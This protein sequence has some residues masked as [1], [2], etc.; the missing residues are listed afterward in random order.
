MFIFFLLL[1]PNVS[2][3]FESAG[4]ISLNPVCYEYYYRFWN[5]SKKWRLKNALSK[6]KTDMR[7]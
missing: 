2:N 3:A 5:S 1:I 7:K 6:A 4:L